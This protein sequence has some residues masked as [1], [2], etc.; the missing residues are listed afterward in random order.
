MNTHIK[1]CVCGFLVLEAIIALALF[2]I[3]VFSIVTL[4]WG[5]R[6]MF[7]EASA[8]RALLDSAVSIAADPLAF[9][10]AF[11]HAAYGNDATIATFS[12]STSAILP[13]AA[14]ANGE[15]PTGTHADAQATGSISIS[16]SI[17]QPDTFSAYGKDTCPPILDFSG[18]MPSTTIAALP[19]PAANDI[20]GLS[21]KDG[22]AYI[23]TDSN[24]AAD[25]DL[26][27][28]DMRDM[29]APEL[30][31][32]LNTGPGLA[33]LSVAGPY[34]FA[35]N[36]S[37]VSQLQVIDI[38]DRSH[39]AAIA[40][41][42]VPL[43]I[44]TST[45]PY[46]SAIYY[47]KGFVYLGTEKGDSPELTVW[48]VAD[49]ALP[50]LSG[51]YEIGNKVEKILAEGDRMYIAGTGGN[52]L[53]T[54]DVTN[55]TALALLSTMAPRGFLTQNGQALDLFDGSVAFGRDTGG[56]NN[57]ANPEF[58]LYDASNIAPQG[59][60]ALQSSFDEP[61]GA[62]AIVARPPYFL[63]LTHRSSG[64]FRLDSA[65]GM[66]SAVYNI[67]GAPA[68]LS[69][70]WGTM[71]VASNSNNGPTLTAIKDFHE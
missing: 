18:R 47:D 41:V 69:C 40:Q 61:G 2:S 29:A 4:S 17:L 23:S 12:S 51:R 70:D 13:D 46:A 53:M 26:Y 64:Q 54:F 27:I 19:I 57:T 37:S 67:S 15:P 25:P 65:T 45:A 44:S 49:P 43:D 63:V 55:P 50:M 14:L 33:D 35:A 20:T 10:A 34:V 39:P 9:G 1:N 58:M 42:K 8:R 32:S 7:D 11:A 71:Y 28:F 48:N 21:V 6:R 62:Y 68:A 22:F 66:A 24:I 5:S 16:F 3:C 30:V 56:Y 60:L 52:Q 31:S 36:K 59:Q 38:H